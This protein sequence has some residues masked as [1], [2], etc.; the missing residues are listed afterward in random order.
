[1]R[2]EEKSGKRKTAHFLEHEKLKLPE[3]DPEKLA[4]R[5]LEIWHKYESGA[6]TS[7]EFKAYRKYNYEHSFGNS[8]TLAQYIA[9]LVFDWDS[10]HEKFKDKK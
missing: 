10:Y 7:E 3:L 1:M 6:L 4:E 2:D 8:D 5:D 9:N